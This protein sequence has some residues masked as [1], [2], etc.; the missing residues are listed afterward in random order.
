MSKSKRRK[1]AIR[2]AK[3]K[4]RLIVAAISVAVL[5]AI[6]GIIIITTMSQRNA[7]RVYSLGG[8]AVTLSSDNSFAAVL[9]HGDIKIGSFTES[10]EDGFTTVTFSYDGT[11]ADARIEGNVLHI[12]SQWDDL[13]L[14]GTEFVL[15]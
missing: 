10:E 12:P 8:A 13:H 2:K 14:H 15:R 7:D 5:A 9:W 1:E 6:V 3:R 4:K 11:T